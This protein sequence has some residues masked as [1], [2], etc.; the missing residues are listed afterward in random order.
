MAGAFSEYLPH[1]PA[2]VFDGID[3]GGAQKPFSGEG[4]PPPPHDAIAEAVARGRREAEA[5]AELKFERLLAEERADLELRLAEKEEYWRKEVAEVLAGALTGGLKRI[6]TSISDEAARALARFLPGAIRERA[7]GELSQ[8]LAALLADRAAT[9]I[10]I[11]GPALL[12]ERLRPLLAEHEVEIVPDARADVTVK[13][14]D[15]VIET[16]MSAWVRRIETA[17]AGADDV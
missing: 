13:I 3:I 4:V 10:V 14:D 17:V 8:T 15:T 9:R 2:A 11:S 16:C 7:L 6:E 1:F 5:A 12:V